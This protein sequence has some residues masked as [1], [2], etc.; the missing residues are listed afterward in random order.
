MFQRK[1]R[2]RQ[3]QENK[4]LVVARWQK[5]NDTNNDTQTLNNRF[6]YAA[7]WGRNS[8]ARDAQYK[9]VGKKPVLEGFSGSSLAGT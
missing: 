9:I 1:G 8:T 6:N 3:K 7:G 4:T 5:A 2:K